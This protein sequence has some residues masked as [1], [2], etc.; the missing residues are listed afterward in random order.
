MIV[1]DP[2]TNIFGYGK[3]IDDFLEQLGQIQVE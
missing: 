2:K 3:Q 1:R